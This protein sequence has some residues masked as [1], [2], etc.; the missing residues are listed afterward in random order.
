MGSPS[1]S[2]QELSLQGPSGKV[3]GALSP[4]SF[5]HLR[6]RSSHRDSS[7]ELCSPVGG[8]PSC[9]LVGSSGVSGGERQL[10]EGRAGGAVGR[11]G[12]L[13]SGHSC[14]RAGVSAQGRRAS[15]ATCPR[16]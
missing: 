1:V 13:G 3:P 10:A 14:R 8:R 6:S 9:F 16:S 12:Q 2:E 15:L 7:S 11:A 5:L 4:Q